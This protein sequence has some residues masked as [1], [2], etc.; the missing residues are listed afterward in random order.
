MESDWIL[1]VLSDL[2][3]FATSNDLPKLAAQLDDA[4]LIAMAELARAPAQPGTPKP[5]EAL[6]PSKKNEP[7]T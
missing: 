6:S 1:D 4:A 3:T 7:K 5:V 2:R